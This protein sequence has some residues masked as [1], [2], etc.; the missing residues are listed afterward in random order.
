MNDANRVFDLIAR[1]QEC[2]AQADADNQIWPDPLPLPDGLLPV[3]PFSMDLLPRALHTW[4]ADIAD[5][6]QCPPDYPG[7][8]AVAALGVALGR[9]IG[10]RPKF[11]DNWTERGNLWLAII[12]RP[13][14]MKTPAMTAV[15]KPLHSLADL[16]HQTFVT[17]QADYEHS[18]MKAE[19]LNEAARST[20]KANVKK[21]GAAADLQQTELPTPP[22][23]V[24]LMTTDSTVEALAEVLRDNPQGIGVYRDELVGL[25]RSLDREGQE[26]ARGF[27][28]QGWNGSGSWTV[29]RI[30]RGLY[31]HVPHVALSVIGS[32]QPGRLREYVREATSGGAG[33]DGLLQ[34]FML[35]WPDSNSAWRHVDRYP[36]NKA[37]MQAQD[38][39]SRLLSV[40]PLALQAEPDLNAD[41]HFLRLSPEASEVFIEW[42][43][44][45]EAT[46]RDG[47]VM[48]ALEAFLSKMRKTVPALALLFHL[49][50]CP[51]GGAV[52]A[53]SMKRAVLW[54][55]Y[56][57]SHA[58]RA[59]SYGIRPDTDAAVN[60]DRNL[61][62]SGG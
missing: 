24:R 15:L 48:P 16:A 28:L 36:D 37:A 18:K 30:G 26:G 34:R 5:R 6:V 8:T 46:L 2:A 7:A 39:Y 60:A 32:I 55:T 17:A 50:D 45:L 20:F 31:L 1:N 58:E 62:G 27:Y 42:L 10:I 52:G 29:D 53:A 11:R 54:S 12:G 41:D 51:E 25:L 35:A 38:V 9:K 4:V 21:L 47:S 3:E 57:R 13:G 61:H 22:R 33:D 23:H 40:D 56:L 43:T 59:Y 44:L 49:A 14:A 19:L